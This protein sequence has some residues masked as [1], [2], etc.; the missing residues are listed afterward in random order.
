[1]TRRSPGKPRRRSWLVG[2]SVLIV[3]F[4][5]NP[6][7]AGAAHSAVS[8]QGGGAINGQLNDGEM[9]PGM[10][11][12]YDG[13]LVYTSVA[14]AYNGVYAV[15]GNP[16]AGYYTGPLTVRYTVPAGTYQNASGSLGPNCVG[17][18]GYIY[19]GVTG[20]VDGAVANLRVD[21]DFGSGY[22]R[23]LGGTVEVE[24][25]GG[26]R[27]SSN[28]GVTWTGPFPTHQRHV[29]VQAFVPPVPEES[30]GTETFTT[31]PPA[32]CLMP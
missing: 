26:C 16:L 8:G 1:M 14:N 28:G 7:P 24:L 3:G 30:N 27:F 23:R 18:P 5:V 32:V 4:M 11:A 31:C 13:T 25:S 20:T 2:L 10:C 15:T 22:Y 21:C 9:V 12:R 17:G 29:N 19:G 6:T